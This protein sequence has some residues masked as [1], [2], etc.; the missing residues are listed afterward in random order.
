MPT[1][2]VMIPAV[3]RISQIEKWKPTASGVM[4]TEPK[5]ILCV[6]N[7]DDANQ[8]AMYAPIA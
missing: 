6:A 1:N 2:A 5:W 4:P 7:C 8:P 3:A